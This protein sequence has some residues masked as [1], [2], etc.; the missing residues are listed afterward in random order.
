[1]R[2]VVR[3]ATLSLDSDLEPDP[4]LLIRAAQ[5][6][7]GWRICRWPIDWP[8]RRSAPERD[9]GE[10]HSRARAIVARPRQ[11][12]RC[13]AGR[14]VHQRIERHR[15]RQTRLPARQQHALCARRPRGG[16]EAHRRRSRGPRRRHARGCID[17][18]SPC[19]GRDGQAG[20]G[21]E[22]VRRP[23]AGPAAR[24][25]RSSTAWAIASIAAEAGRTA[26]AVAAADAGYVAAARSFDTPHTRFNIADAPISALLLSGPDRGSAGTWPRVRA[27]RQPISPVL[28]S[29]TAVPPWRVGPPS[30]PATSTP[31]L[32]PLPGRQALDSAGE[33]SAG[34]TAISFPT[35]SR[36]PC[37]VHDR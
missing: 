37:A 33:A 18:F 29:Y 26:E 8:M 7:T 3:R 6:A 1:M 24:G 4:D 20:S 31:H 13:A 19:T 28:L 22:G 27:S 36:W 14:V 5:G 11:G 35:R 30:A 17:A 32:A 10:F 21:D 16:E 34:D 25:R 23:G 2:V 9:G 12:S 15:S